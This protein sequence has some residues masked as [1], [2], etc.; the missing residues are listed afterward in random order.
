MV[1]LCEHIVLQQ[2]DVPGWCKQLWHIGQHSSPKT[3]S[4]TLMDACDKP[5]SLPWALYAARPQA[6]LKVH[7]MFGARLNCPHEIAITT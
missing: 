2:A 4:A 7:K 1:W 5:C 6:T 3:C